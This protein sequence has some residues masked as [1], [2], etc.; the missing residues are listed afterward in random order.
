M[1][2]Q[3]LPLH[4]PPKINPEIKSLIK[5]QSSG[6]VSLTRNARIL[7]KQEILNAYLTAVSK[8]ITTIIDEKRDEENIAIMDCANDLIM[9]LAN[10]SRRV[11]DSLQI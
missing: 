1:G 6:S 2:Y 8:I 5:K 4:R 10:K 9:L 11:N 7:M 3:K